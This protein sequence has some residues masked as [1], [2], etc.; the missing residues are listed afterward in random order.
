MFIFAN[1]LFSF[2]SFQSSQWIQHYYFQS[3]KKKPTQYR[4]NKGKL[5]KQRVQAKIYQKIVMKRNVV[6]KDQVD[7]QETWILIIAWSVT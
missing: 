5:P 4:K 7:N 6:L 2:Q 1:Q 3:K